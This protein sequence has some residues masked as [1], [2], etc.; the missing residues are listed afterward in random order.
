LKT[1]TIKT[2]AQGLIAPRSVKYWQ[3]DDKNQSRILLVEKI[4]RHNNG[5]GNRRV[6]QSSDVQPRMPYNND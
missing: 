1:V 4:E 5:N 6:K 3:S 2:K